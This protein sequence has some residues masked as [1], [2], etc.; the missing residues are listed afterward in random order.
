MTADALAELR[1]RIDQATRERL[2]AD[3]DP[4][5]RPERTNRRRTS[6]ARKNTTAT[7]APGRKPAS[8]A[9]APRKPKDAAVEQASP[10]APDAAAPPVEAPPAAPEQ[11]APAAAEAW[12]PAPLVA[13]LMTEVGKAVAGA[14]RVDPKSGSYFRIMVEK[15][16]LAYV[17]VSKKAL[18]LDLATPRDRVPAG[19]VVKDGPNATLPVKYKLDP[20]VADLGVR[21]AVE[22]VKIAAAKEGA[23]A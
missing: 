5:V 3:N 16:T 1:S 6:M 2:I 18:T 7:T 13:T 14:K 9:R 4:I 19:I 8:R 10:A 21:E 11:P 22:L 23:A 17:N 15:T 20:T 12:D